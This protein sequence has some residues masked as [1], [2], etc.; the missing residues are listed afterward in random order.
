MAQE[1]FGNGLLFKQEPNGQWV[2]EE[3][4]RTPGHTHITNR[5]T[6]VTVRHQNDAV[7]VRNSEDP[8]KVTVA[9]TLE[10][11]K[12]FTRGVRDGEFDF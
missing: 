4:F 8:T 11:W 7:E 9:F 12:T 5:R 3:G 10:E 6:C 2:D 1:R